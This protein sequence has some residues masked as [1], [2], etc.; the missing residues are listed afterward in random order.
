M[1]LANVMHISF[2]SRRRCLQAATTG[3]RM[4]RIMTGP[5]TATTMETRT[6]AQTMG[7][8]TGEDEHNGV[9]CCMYVSIR[10]PEHFQNGHDLI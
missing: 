7:P 3:S 6:K 10:P 8:T 2:S 9:T 5:S 1:T 4:G